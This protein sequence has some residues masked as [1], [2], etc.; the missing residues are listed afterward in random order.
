MYCPWDVLNY[1]NDLQVD[2]R[3]KPGNYWKNTSHNSIIRSFVDRTDLEIHDKFEILLAGGCIKEKITDDL[4]YDVLHASEAN[5]W[6][7]LYLTGYLTRAEERNES[8]AETEKIWLK[9]PNEE[10]RL[11]FADTISIW[12]ED[13]MRQTDRTLLFDALWRG[14]D[15]EAET[16]INNIL[17]DT[18][19]YYDYKE[20]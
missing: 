12:F 17:F 1:V 9:I 13:G 8:H 18:I 2:D 3:A 5:L 10:I 7:V 15:K 4:T 19:S 14:D 16:L 20:D 6:S 11:I